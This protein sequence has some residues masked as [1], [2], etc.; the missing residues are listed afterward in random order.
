MLNLQAYDLDLFAHTST[1]T[2]RQEFAIDGLLT[3]EEIGR[4][5]EEGYCVTVRKHAK[6]AA[7]AQTE[8]TS[9]QEWLKAMEE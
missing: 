6:Q 9:F 2:D 3:L 7:R 8:V 1:I 4:L 5:V